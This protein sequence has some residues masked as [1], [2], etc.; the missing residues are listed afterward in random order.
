[1]NVWPDGKL[2]IEYDQETDTLSLWNG[3]PASEGRD[4]AESLVADLD[5]AG[6][7]VGFTLE[8][9]GALLGPALTTSPVDDATRVAA[10]LRTALDRILEPAKT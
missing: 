5:A 7:V 3:R 9:A 1:M 8:H 2:T 4:I 6:N 10:A